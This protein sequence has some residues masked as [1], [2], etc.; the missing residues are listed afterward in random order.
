LAGQTADSVVEGNTQFDTDGIS[1]QNLY[2]AEDPSC[3]DCT[4]VATFFQASVE[5]RGNT[6]QGEYDWESDCSESGILLSLGASPTPGAKP[7]NASF[8]VSISHNTIDHAD[9][10]RGGAIAV[11]R[12]WWG[13]PDPNEHWK[14]VLN[15]LIYSNDIKNID[16]AEPTQACRDPGS[17][18][19]IGINL[20]ESELL[21]RTVL[22]NNSCTS[23]TT[24][25]LDP[26]H[27]QTTKVC[28]ASTAGANS[29][30]CSAVSR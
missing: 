11:V 17:T 4:G 28:P 3:P 9:A 26:G 30:E 16:G 10:Y 19:R 7:V 29:C 1:L 21:W 8:N 23:V 25:L 18:P 27:Q 5:V 24:P 13:G 12:T 20:H 14:L 6:I 2:M 15:P 22:Y